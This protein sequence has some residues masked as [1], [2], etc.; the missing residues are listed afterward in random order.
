MYKQ[1]VGKNVNLDLLVEGILRFLERMGFKC[2]GS[3]KKEARVTG[4]LFHVE[5]RCGSAVVRV[6]GHPNDFSVEFDVG[7]SRLLFDSGVT[8]FGGGVI[9][10]RKLKAREA[11]ERLERE[12]WL[13]ME[14]AVAHLEGSGRNLC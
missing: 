10:L 12:F 6:S 13:F 14:D 8:L 3:L 11:L 7:S 1:W 5:I 2:G 9:L 4:K